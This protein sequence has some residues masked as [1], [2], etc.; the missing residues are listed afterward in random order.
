[1]ASRQ[2]H[3]LNDL[4]LRRWLKDKTPMAKSD[5]GG[6]TFTLSAA[7]TASW[8]LRYRSGGKPQ[9]LTLGRYP[10]LTLSAARKLAAEKRVEVQQGRNPATEKRKAKSRKEWSIRELVADYRQDTMPTLAESTSRSYE[11][12]LKRIEAG[13]GAMLVKEVES[14]DIVGLLERINVGWV[15]ANT[16]LIVHKA[17]FRRAA[18]KRLINSNPALG[19][20][21]SA[22]IGPRPAVKKRLMLTGPELKIILSAKMNTENL[23]SVRIL[24]ATGVRVSELFQAMRSNVQL[25]KAIWHIPSSKTGPGMDIPLAPSVIQW[26]QELLS[27]NQ[28]SRYVLPARATS[29]AER[30]GGDAHVSKDTIREAID[31][32]IDTHKPKVR[33]FTPHDLRSTMKSHMRALGVTRDI[34]EMCLN[35]KLPGVEGIYDQYTYFEERKQALSIWATFLSNQLDAPSS[36]DSPH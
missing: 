34:S 32:W 5:G 27:L 9:E 30:Q 19:I 31:T 6:L 17:I 4:D 3:S 7:G 36:I 26:F 15:E 24:A 12:N 25:D 28:E 18:G 8:I 10:D 13:L 33:R 35:H 20:E 16:L 14:A 29:R 23:L 1:M 2:I 22:V 11:R 21:L